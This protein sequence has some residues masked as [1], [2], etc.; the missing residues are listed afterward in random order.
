MY[1][2][3]RITRASPPP[4]HAAPSRPPESHT[5]RSFVHFATPRGPPLRIPRPAVPNFSPRTDASPWNRRPAHEGGSV[6]RRARRGHLFAQEALLKLRLAAGELLRRGGASGQRL[7]VCVEW[8]LGRTAECVPAYVRCAPK[9]CPRRGRGAR[10]GEPTHLVLLLL[11]LPLTCFDRS[12][13]RRH[14][15]F[16]TSR[17]RRR[18]SPPRR[19]RRGR[20]DV[21]CRSPPRCR[22]RARAR[23]PA[24]VLDDPS[25]RRRRAAP[26]PAASRRAPPA[27]RR[28]ETPA[29]APT[30]AAPATAPAGTG[31]PAARARARGRAEAAA[32]RRG[33]GPGPRAR[34]GAPAAR[35][36]A[37]RGAGARASALVL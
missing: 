17:R 33:A 13:A 20:E 15:I 37:G 2:S 31:R 25:P 22:T 1:C 34:V 30:Q 6:A 14:A 8:V 29:P 35:R 9:S 5:P 27:R 3:A 12:L 10:K 36:R 7:H 4:A 11:N 24:L 28:A 26:A 18:A 19:R 16:A 23:E 21:P 32:G